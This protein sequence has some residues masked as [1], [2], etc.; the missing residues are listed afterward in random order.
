MAESRGEKTGLLLG[1]H[2]K[3]ELDGFGIHFRVKLTEL[4]DDMWAVRERNGIKG[5]S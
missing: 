2:V 1:G 4:D 3:V 5:D